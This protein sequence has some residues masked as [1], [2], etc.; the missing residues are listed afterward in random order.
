MPSA[1]WQVHLHEKYQDKLSFTSQWGI[2]MFKRLPFGLK[3][4]ASYFQ[5]LADS[6][7]EE[8][9]MLGIESY[10][11]DFVICSNPFEE[12]LQKLS[13]FLQVFSK[14]NLTLNLAKC[15]FH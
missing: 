11:D 4:A 5:A 3:N 7:I 8:V 6:I 12:T 14:Y 1:Y 10:Q 13:R 2:H 15:L 9:N